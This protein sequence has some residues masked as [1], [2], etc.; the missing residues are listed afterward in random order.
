MVLM[1][2]V[3]FA[4]IAGFSTGRV[5]YNSNDRVDNLEAPPEKG[6][7]LLS[8]SGN[9][10]EELIASGPLYHGQKPER[11]QDNSTESP[12]PTQMLEASTVPLTP[13]GV[14]KV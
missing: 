9:S 12:V 5:V 13:A 6:S 7:V 1:A 4:F 2:V 14:C 11:M 3:L 8:P 10:K